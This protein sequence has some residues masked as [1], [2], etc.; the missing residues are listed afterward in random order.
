M[1]KQHD[2]HVLWLPE[3]QAGLDVWPP[4]VVQMCGSGRR[5]LFGIDGGISISSPKQGP[6]RKETGDPDCLD[7]LIERSRNGPSGELGSFSRAVERPS[8]GRLV[9]SCPFHV[10]VAEGSRRETD[11]EA[12]NQGPRYSKST[13]RLQ[14]SPKLGAKGHHIFFPCWICSKRVKWP[15]SRRPAFRGYSAAA[16]GRRCIT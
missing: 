4:R 10:R 6:S 11:V 2:R 16:I 12:Q 3:A 14:L 1:E 7:S 13:R 5:F 15:A 9:V 8:S